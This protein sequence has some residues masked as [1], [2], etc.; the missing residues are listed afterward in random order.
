[1]FSIRSR[2]VGASPPRT[3]AN[4]PNTRSSTPLGLSFEGATPGFSV[5]AVVMTDPPTLAIP[6]AGRLL[7]GLLLER[8][9]LARWRLCEES[10]TRRG[11]VA[12]CGGGLH[13]F[14]F[15]AR[16]GTPR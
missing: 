15:R 10:R 7:F 11:R 6:Q 4:T 14:V 8:G 12:A 3:S 1:M 5:V 13:T 9:S 16:H 2:A